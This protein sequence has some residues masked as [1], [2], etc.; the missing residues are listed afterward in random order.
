MVPG[1]ISNQYA[2]SLQL[3]AKKYSQWIPDTYSLRLMFVEGQSC[4]GYRQVDKQGQWS[5]V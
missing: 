2:G 1:Y 5:P 3:Q 4:H